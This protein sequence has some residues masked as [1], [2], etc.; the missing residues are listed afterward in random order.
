[1]IDEKAE[2]LKELSWKLFKI[3]P[4]GVEFLERFKH[5]LSAPVFP[6]DPQV[7]NMHGGAGEYGNF[8]AGQ[9]NIFPMI[10]A[11]IESYISS[12]NPRREE[13]APHDHRDN[14]PIF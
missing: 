1:M 8:R 3:N 6:V 9:M 14:Q 12:N 10:K 4:E 2:R 5:A 11:L 13:Y 7:L